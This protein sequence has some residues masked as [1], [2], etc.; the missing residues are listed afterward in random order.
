M[1]LVPKFPKKVQYLLNFSFPIVKRLCKKN[2]V[3]RF[4]GG[5]P[6]YDRE[7][8]FVLLLIKKVTNWSFRD[9]ASMGEI[10]H[11]TLVRANSFFLKHKVYEKVFT[12]LV[13]RAFAKNLISGQSVAIDSSF[14][15]TFSKKGELGSE[16]WNEFKKGYGFK[17]H[18]L[19]DCLTQF[20]IAA[21]ITNGVASD[22]TLAIPLLS[23][24]KRH[25]KNTGYILGDKGYDDEKIVKWIT[26]ETEAK[27]GIPIRKKS[28][29]AKGKKYRYGNLL[30]WLLKTKGR[31]FK[32][33]IYN[34][35]TAVE[36]S[37]SQLKRV[38]HLG[39]EE[40]RGILSFAKNVYLS[41]ICYMLKL[42]NIAKSI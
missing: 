37:F 16:N 28:I 30:N 29:L 5:R 26:S 42:F 36:R 27:A 15:H 19:V 2:S 9:V 10:S 8:L 3:E 7:L 18:L 24:A 4:V 12:H 6:G 23:K 22:N 38:Y 21:T 11:S 14:V 31:T 41:L 32:K 20:P 13:R 1:T 25:L 17:L 34:K 40:T 35:R 33:S 39:H